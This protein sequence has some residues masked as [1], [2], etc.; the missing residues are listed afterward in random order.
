MHTAFAEILA[1]LYPLF[2][3]HTHSQLYYTSKLHHN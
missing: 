1:F 2:I 3:T